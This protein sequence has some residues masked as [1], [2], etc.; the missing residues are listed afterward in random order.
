MSEMFLIKDTH[1]RRLLLEDLVT[2]LEAGDL[3]PLL[4]AG[5]EPD[6]LE[7]LRQCS[8]RDLQRIA[9]MP[10]DV[11][12][13]VNMPALGV[14][15]KRLAAIIE[16]RRVIEYHIR[17]GAPTELMVRVFK[18]SSA[19]LRAQR[20]A[21][22]ADSG[23]RGRPQLPPEDVRDAIHRAWSQVVTEYDEKQRF[24]ILHQRFPQYSIGSLWH[25]VHE[26]DADA[27]AKAHAPTRRVQGT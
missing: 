1:I 25:A 8:V 15:F 3:Q 7:D 9:E 17:H 12:V 27:R 26:F 20:E 10:L 11:G 22:C 16:D 5:F 6:L 23:N 13:I 19:E 14:A 4:D 2:R 21:I 24:M 18:L